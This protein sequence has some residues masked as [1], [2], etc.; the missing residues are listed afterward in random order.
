MFRQPRSVE[1]TNATAALRAKLL[2][3]TTDLRRCARPCS[4][5]TCCSMRRLAER[6]ICWRFGT[7]GNCHS[8]L[9]GIGDDKLTP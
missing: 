4:T 5:I 3:L 1:T 7:S 6:F 9:K 2:A 8:T